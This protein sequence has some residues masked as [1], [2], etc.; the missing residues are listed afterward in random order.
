MEVDV[1]AFCN[2][3]CAIILPGTCNMI[4]YIVASFS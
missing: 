1:S 4:V 2:H 3:A